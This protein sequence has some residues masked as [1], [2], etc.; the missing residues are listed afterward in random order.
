MT[1]RVA[2]ALVPALLGSL[3]TFVL[4]AAPAAAHCDG[5][6]GP[7]VAAARRAL[8][9][10]SVRPALMWVRKED[11]VELSLAFDRTLAVLPMGARAKE[12][13]ELYFFETL[14]RLHR[15]GEG[16]AYTGLAPA[17]RNLGAAIPVADR[18]VETA[19]LKPVAALLKREL[20]A[21]LSARFHRMLE[22]KRHVGTD[23][24]A[25][26][27]FVAA[28]VEFVHYVERL[29]RGAV[30]IGL[31]HVEDPSAPRGDTHPEPGHGAIHPAGTETP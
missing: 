25:D 14:V 30:G 19:D 20:D 4:G 13:A 3:A 22:A 11:E 1:T 21:G 7:V 9:A 28:Y 16:A 2:F 23:L 29:H 5:L 15:T 31:G 12:L 27:R 26:R 17:G 24:E 6:D 18:S 10:R 8:D